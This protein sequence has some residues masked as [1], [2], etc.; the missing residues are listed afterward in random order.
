MVSE[1]QT[2]A[3]MARRRETI[4][5]VPNFMSGHEKKTVT[6]KVDSSKAE[7][8]DP[9]KSVDAQP[10][11]IPDLVLLVQA[12]EREVQTAE[13]LRGAILKSLAKSKKRVDH[14]EEKVVQ[15]LS[16]LMETCDNMIKSVDEQLRK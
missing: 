14:G 9:G 13:N 3:Q 5:R 8:L 15:M 1:R 7:S 6:S 12:A 11:E 16:N 10:K 4:Y 2:T